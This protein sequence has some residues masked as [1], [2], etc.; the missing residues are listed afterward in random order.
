MSFTASCWKSGASHLWIYTMRNHAWIEL[1]GDPLG[2]EL[3]CWRWRP[4]RST[5]LSHQGI[6]GAFK[7]KTIF[8]CHPWSELNRSSESNF[9]VEC[10]P[11]DFTCQ[12]SAEESMRERCYCDRPEVECSLLP[13]TKAHW[14]VFTSILTIHAPDPQSSILFWITRFRLDPAQTQCS[15]SGRAVLF[16][17]GA[18]WRLGTHS[19]VNMKSNRVNM[20]S[21]DMRFLPHLSE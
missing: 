7:N 3:P 18:N 11:V 13:K 6:K 17:T 8:L 5:R 12:T 2:N 4:A 16:L 21:T 10:C 9:L 19:W 1:P 20:K 15:S 14:S